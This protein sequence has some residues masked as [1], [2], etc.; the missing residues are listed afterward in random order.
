M[1]TIIC[2]YCQTSFDNLFEI[3]YCPHCG[4]ENIPLSEDYQ[5]LNEKIEDF[6]TNLFLNILSLDNANGFTVISHS[7]KSISLVD[8]IMEEPFLSDFKNRRIVAFISF[9]FGFT[10]TINNYSINKFNL[11]YTFE[12]SIDELEQLFFAPKETLSNI[13]KTN[14][15]NESKKLEI[16]EEEANAINKT[17]LQTNIEDISKKFKELKKEYFNVM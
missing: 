2:N 3:N 12:L 5:L 7:F 9:D 14:N 1:Q 10:T 15:I 17:I 6:D 8:T 11:S 13:I 4:K 16:T